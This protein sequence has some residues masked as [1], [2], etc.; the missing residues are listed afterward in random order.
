ML[1]EWIWAPPPQYAG[2]INPKATDEDHVIGMVSIRKQP[3]KNFKV[4]VDTDCL[5][6]YQCM[7]SPYNGAVFAYVHRSLLTSPER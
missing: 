1:N 7:W 4:L 5:L 6:I 3:H 2:E